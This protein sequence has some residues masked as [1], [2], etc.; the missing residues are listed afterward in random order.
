VYNDA[1]PSLESESI[2]FSIHCG[3][4]VPLLILCAKLS[5]RAF[6]QD[7]SDIFV[8]LDLRNAS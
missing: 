8:A 7:L 2:M 4:N 1:A 6:A 5:P 3:K